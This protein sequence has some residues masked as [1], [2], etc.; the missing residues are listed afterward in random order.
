MTKGLFVWVEGVDWLFT[1]K[2]TPAV[3]DALLRLKEEK[4]HLTLLGKKIRTFLDR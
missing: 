3:I 1:K 4:D 2:V